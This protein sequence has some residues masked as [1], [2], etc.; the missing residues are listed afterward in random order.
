MHT[1]RSPGIK[2]WVTLVAAAIVILLVFS[3]AYLY[4]EQ[5]QGQV[6]T[7][8][9][10]PQI[11]T[12]TIEYPTQA[13][14][15][16]PN[17]IGLDS[18]GNVWFTLGNVSSLA[19]LT[20]SNGT[21]HEYHVPG[22]KNGA[23]MSWG[24]AIDEATST[25]WFSDFSSNSI[26]SFGMADHVFVQ[27]KLNTPGALPFE[28]TID[29]NQNVWFTEDE[30]NKIGEITSNG[31]LNE[32]PV[33]IA[34]ATPAGITVSPNGTV[35][36]TMPDAN[37][38]GS[39]ADGVFTYYNFTGVASQPVGISMDLS[40]NLWM[41]QH[42][43]SFISEFNPATHYFMTI[44]TSNNSLDDSLPYFCYV[45]SGG[46]V[47]INEHYGNAE[48]EFLPKNDTL[49]EYFIPSAIVDAGNISYMLTS[50]VTPAGVPWY[51]EF[52]T[53]KIGTLNIS[54]P[55]DVGISLPNYTRPISM[56]EGNS[57][58]GL[59]LSVNSG[60]HFVSLKAYVGNFTGNFTF[61]FTPSQ[62]NETLNSSLHIKSNGSAP[63]V[64][65]V[66]ITARTNSL[67]VSK[68]IEIKVA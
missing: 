54:Q 13:P 10:T 18:S 16:S 59:N 35:W 68:I 19:E 3:L 48:A 37:S 43:V 51:T 15:T 55:L 38:I 40:G 26:W 65:F 23:M 5:R 21:V 8:I 50:T 6:V 1:S 60:V 27:H 14:T 63:G 57:S 11:G 20:P 62:G 25:I 66:T 44:S 53:G 7:F 33:A 22:I 49:L 17:A 47:W 9:S 24:L 29:R 46:D 31:T 39:F 12:Y 30:G 41:T 56:A 61:T 2:L 42:G 28:V 45:D 52:E 4:L 32:Y 36:F 58:A 67:A 64:Y 34:A